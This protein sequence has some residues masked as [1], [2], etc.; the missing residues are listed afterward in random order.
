MT[1]LPPSAE[2][3]EPQLR[4]SSQVLKRHFDVNNLIIISIRM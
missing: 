2:T 1:V 3:H 4:P